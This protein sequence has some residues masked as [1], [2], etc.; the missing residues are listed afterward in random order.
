MKSSYWDKGMN[1]GEYAILDTGYLL[2]IG[3]FSH[4]YL[5]C[6]FHILPVGK[7]D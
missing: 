3:V 4:F 2:F 1:S 7:G 5:R 6:L